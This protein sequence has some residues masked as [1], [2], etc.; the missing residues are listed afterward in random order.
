LASTTRSACCWRRSL[1]TPSSGPPTVRIDIGDRPSGVR[2]HKVAE[3][4]SS[5]GPVPS[6]TSGGLSF[7]VARE[8]HRS[9]QQP[10]E[11]AA[12]RAT[13]C[14][15]PVLSVTSAIASDSGACDGDDFLLDFFLSAA[16]LASS[17]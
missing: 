17:G 14:T 9:P 12:V 13:G 10:G 16:I 3:A 11:H 2:A 1:R 6:V 8:V 15:L 7:E 4:R 5:C